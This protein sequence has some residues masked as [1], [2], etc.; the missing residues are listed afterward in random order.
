MVFR[1]TEIVAGVDPDAGEIVSHVAEDDAVQES[2][3]PWP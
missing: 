1:E 3:V 2:N